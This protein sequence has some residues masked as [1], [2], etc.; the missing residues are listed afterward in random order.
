MIV[1]IWHTKVDSARIAEFEQFAIQQSLP[2]FRQ[3]AGLLG[4]FFT[5]STDEF[6]TIT[7]WENQAAVDALATSPTYQDTVSRIKATGFLIGDQRVDVF[8]TWGGFMVENLANFLA[9]S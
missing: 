8:E 6:Q 7:L 4:V 2:M 5:R 1:R 3:Q 9:E